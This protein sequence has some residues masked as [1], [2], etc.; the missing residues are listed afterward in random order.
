MIRGPQ[1][2]V[3]TIQL[4]LMDGEITLITA[5]ESK[6]VRAWNSTEDSCWPQ[7]Y[8]TGTWNNWAFNGMLSSPDQRAV[9]KYRLRIGE[10][11]MEEFQI[12]VERDWS[13]QMYPH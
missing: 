1:G 3:V 6:G 5:S 9:F 10:S 7:Y 11:G 12:V 13:K 4:R 8:V 2:E